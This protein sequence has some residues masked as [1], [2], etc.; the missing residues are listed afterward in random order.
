MRAGEPL[1]LHWMAAAPQGSLG[2]ALCG[3]ES[4]AWRCIDDD[5]VTAAEC[6]RCAEVGAA[7]GTEQQ[8]P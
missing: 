8:V 2:R 3:A 6:P 1:V 5:R 4:P 7:P